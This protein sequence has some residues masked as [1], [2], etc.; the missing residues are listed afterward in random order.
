MSIRNMAG[1][2]P[3]LPFHVA[4]ARGLNTLP[5]DLKVRLPSSSHIGEDRTY[6]QSRVGK[7]LWKK[8]D[9][10]NSTW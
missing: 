1:L 8:L 9:W 5:G 7:R 4:F 3:S 10:A 2:S 6:R